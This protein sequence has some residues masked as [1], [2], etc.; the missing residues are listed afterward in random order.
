MSLGGTFI[1]PILYC[2]PAPAMADVMRD[3]PS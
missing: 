3:Q 2:G 1:T